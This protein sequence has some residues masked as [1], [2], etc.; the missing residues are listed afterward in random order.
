MYTQFNRSR[1]AALSRPDKVTEFLSIYLII[2]AALGHGV[3]SA[4]N[5][6]LVPETNKNCFWGIER[7]W[8][9]RLTSL[10][11]VSRLSRQCGILN[12]STA[13]HWDSFFL[14]S[15][16][17]PTSTCEIEHNIKGVKLNVFKKIE[18]PV[19][20]FP[21]S[22]IRFGCLLH[23]FAVTKSITLRS[24]GQAGAMLLRFITRIQ[25]RALFVT[26]IAHEHRTAKRQNYELRKQEFFSLSQQAL[27]FSRM[28]SLFTMTADTAR[29]TI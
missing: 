28:C 2:P 6:K 26:S 27:A 1:K 8:C 3:Y 17:N 22:H 20:Q 19:E 18:I 10:S 7:G 11:S 14:L 21:S 16:F 24:G 12:I 5:R 4:S 25:Y 9:V 23:T 29:P 13:C 15:Q